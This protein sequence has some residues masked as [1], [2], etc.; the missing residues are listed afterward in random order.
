[1]LNNVNLEQAQIA[2]QQGD[3]SWLAQCLQQL[4]DTKKSSS[5]PLAEQK[6]LQLLALALDVLV[7]GD[8]SARWKVAK[9]FPSI[10]TA[11]VTPLITILQDDDAD[12]E[13]RW[14]AARILGEFDDPQVIPALVE[15][16]QTS[17]DHDLNAMAAEALAN[18]GPSAIAHLTNLLTEA[19]TRLLAVRSLCQI[20]RTETI[21]PL[22][23][24][25][26]DPQIAVRA[27]AI[28]ALSSFHDPQVPPVLI[29]ALSDP[30]AQVRRP[31]VSGLGFRADLIQELDLVQV[32]QPLL[33]DVDLE[34]CQQAA[35][36]L[37]RLGTESA[38]AA[39]FQVLQSP[40]TLVQV[41]IVRALAWIET[42]WSLEYLQQALSLESALAAYPE[43][44]TVLG[45]VEQPDLIPQAVQILIDLLHS[46][47]ATQDPLVK[48]S[49]A[50]SLGQLGSPSAV[51]PLIE[52][53]AADAGVRLH[54]I[55]ALK[56]LAPQAHHQLAALAQDQQ[57]APELKQGVAIALQEWPA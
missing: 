45:R 47:P 9:L 10:G 2:A 22:I 52:L 14:F 34:V 44:A 27:T 56:K 12:L 31:A 30:A 26:H 3:W 48:Q 50:Q 1:M 28:E 13:L 36:A 40:A 42:S 7:G 37:G 43:I 6:D 57:L 4:L 11:A 32:L 51:T 21:A 29:Q 46:G 18:L 20:R 16:L 55:A 8:F 25:V 15:L 54:A 24:V 35:I 17:G 49:I 41:P 39:L 5:V 53:L 38:A 19:R 23:S 33:Q